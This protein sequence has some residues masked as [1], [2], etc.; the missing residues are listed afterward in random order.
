MNSAEQFSQSGQRVR[1]LLLVIAVLLPG[2]C[3]CRLFVA[4]GKMVMGNPESKSSFEQVTGTNLSESKKRLL[5]I[6]T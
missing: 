4:V 5:I 3:G 2:F 6:C 1:V